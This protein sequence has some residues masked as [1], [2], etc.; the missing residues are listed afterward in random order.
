MGPAPTG[1]CLRMPRSLIE[2]LPHVRSRKL[3]AKGAVFNDKLETGQVHLLEKGRPCAAKLGPDLTVGGSGWAPLNLAL[4][5]LARQR[6][7]GKAVTRC[8]ELSCDSSR[9]GQARGTPRPGA[10]A[11]CR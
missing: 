7:E 1:A 11:S 10:T 9:S 8:S 4:A 5:L 2:A 3:E 6:A